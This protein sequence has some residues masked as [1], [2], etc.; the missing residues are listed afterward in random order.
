VVV[1]HRIVDVLVPIDT[2]EVEQVLLIDRF[3]HFR[4]NLGP[5]RG[6]YG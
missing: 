3:P 1:F 4:R 2:A 5:G 6:R